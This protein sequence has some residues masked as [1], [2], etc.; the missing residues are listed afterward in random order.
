MRTVR[1]DLSIRTLFLIAGLLVVIWLVTNLWEILILSGAAVMLA[2][3]LFPIVEWLTRHGVSRIVAIV[4]LALSLLLIV[5]G[6]AV[7]IVPVV[8]DQ[9]TDAINQMPQ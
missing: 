2:A 1:F 6:I 4:L 3:A 7:L 9:A 5:A 8:Y